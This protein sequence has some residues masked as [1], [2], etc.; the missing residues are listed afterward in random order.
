MKE[1]GNC[2]NRVRGL[3]RENHISLELM[4]ELWP[5]LNRL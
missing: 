3:R 1:L 4:M 2:L 5:V